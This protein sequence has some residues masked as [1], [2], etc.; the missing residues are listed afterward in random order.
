LRSPEEATVVHLAHPYRHATLADVDALTD[1]V[2]FAG[3][4]LPA[5]LWAKM[6]APGETARD[7]GRRRAAR[8]EGA[9]SYRHAVVADEGEGAIAALVGYGLASEPE[10]IGPDMPSMFVP[11]QELENLA[12]ATWYVNVLAVYPDHRNRGHGIRLLAIAD[13]IAREAGSRGLSIIVADANLGAR[14]LYERFGF[15][16]IGTRAMIKEQWQGRGERWVLMVR[17]GA[18]GA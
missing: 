3:D 14:R 12:C 7:V 1:L 11:M 16:E 5:Y 6:A 18:E 10:P 13:A 17:P 4:G 15:R 8:E 9:F 2:D